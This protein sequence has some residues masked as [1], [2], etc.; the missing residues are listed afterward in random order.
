MSRNKLDEN[1]YVETSSNVTKK[2]IFAIDFLK[3]Y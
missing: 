2:T 1:E 3:A